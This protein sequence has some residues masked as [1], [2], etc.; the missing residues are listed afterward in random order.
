MRD[1]IFR[2][3]VIAMMRRTGAVVVAGMLVLVTAPAAGAEHRGF[4]TEIQLPDGWRP[5]GIATGSGPYAYVGSLADGDIWRADLRTGKGSV[6]SQGPGTPTVGIKVDR[7]GRI[8]AAGGPAGTA[9]VVDPRTGAIISNTRLS[10]GTPTF[11]ND[12][13]VTKNTAWF[14]DS[15]TPEPALYKVGLGRDGLPRSVTR[16]PLT[17]DLVFNPTGANANGIATTPDGRALLVVQSNAGKLF[18]VDPGTGVTTTVD[19]GGESLVNGDGMLRQGRTLYVVQNRLNVIAVL[20]LSR[21]GTSARV[22]GRITDPRFDVPTT[23]APF[24]G[25]LY[26]PNARFTT[27]PTPTTSY[28]V[29]GVKA[30]GDLG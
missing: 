24:G 25:R 4:P 2:E 16:L 22:V 21:D 7:R 3:G 20:K 6:I 30:R 14:T 28:N 13:I 23:V 18:R 1:L 9:R 19:I 26:L 29:I 12:V 27:T 8:F 17:G 5:E 11:I 15:A 10:T